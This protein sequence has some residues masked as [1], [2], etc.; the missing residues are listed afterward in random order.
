LIKG[1][2]IDLVEIDRLESILEKHGE[3]FLE[4]VFVQEEIEYSRGYSRPATH[5]AARF[6]VKEAFRKA[7]GEDGMPYGWREV[8]TVSESTGAPKLVFSE[9]LAKLFEGEFFHLT[10]SH[11]DRD[12]IAMVVREELD[13]K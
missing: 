7:A 12:A 5:F 2:G 9:R 8:W 13:R 11:T 3:R 1:I 4:K 6:A 10:I